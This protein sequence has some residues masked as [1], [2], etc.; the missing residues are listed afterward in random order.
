[1][2]LADTAG[3]TTF[4][5]QNWLRNSSY[6]NSIFNDANSVMLVS[7][8]NV[9]PNI[10][11][12]ANDVNY[13]MPQGG[14]PAL[15]GADFTNPN[16]SGFANVNYRGAFGS[17][18]W[19]S[20]WSQF[21]PQNYTVIG[22]NQISS[23]VPE[24]FLLMQNYPN[25]FN[26]TTRIRFEIPSDVRS[27]L[28]E[29]RLAIYDAIGK[30]VSTLVNEKLSPGSYEVEYKAGNLPSG[31]YFYELKTGNFTAVKKMMLIK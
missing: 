22:V 28:S 6:S 25:P 7:P 17:T 8:F 16:L 1:M 26:P 21:N 31:I 23:E 9:Y 5:G 13:W 12:P 29:V 10:P 30:Q 11:L 3:S 4:G 2:K 27:Q 19:T 14:S 20:G 15:T 24:S 18:N